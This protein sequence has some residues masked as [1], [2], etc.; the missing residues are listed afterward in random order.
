VD[1][2]LT[3]EN[4]RKLIIAHVLPADEETIALQDCLHR[5]PSCNLLSTIPVPHFCQSTMDGYAVNGKSL[6]GVKPPLELPI[7]GEIAAGC[8]TIA[9]LAE[10]EAVRIMTGGSVPAGAD[11]VIPFEWC[12]EAHGRVVIFRF[13]RKG[14]YIRQ[15]GTDLNK[16]QL[17]IRKGEM[18]TPLHLHLL[19]TSGMPLVRVFARPQVSFL[20]TGSEL[21][22]KSP[23]P[24]Q[25]ISGNRA[26]LDGLIR[27]AGGI[28][29]DLGVGVDDTDHIAMKLQETDTSHI[30]ITTG[31][32][33]PGKY[34]LMGEV[35]EKIGVKIL[36]RALQV[37][38]GRA[39]IFGVRDQTLFFSLPGPPPAVHM[40]FNEL[41]RP[42]I[43]A[44]QGKGSVP[45]K[46]RAILEEDIVIRKSGMLN[47]KS[48]ITA[49]R[50][51]LFSV[52][53]AG[54][55]EPSSATILIPANRRLIRAGEKVTIHLH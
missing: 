49:I 53:P 48:G 50:S 19:A 17:I 35:L 45:E 37:R 15:V 44:L 3:L 29:R 41:V 30:T 33:G 26:L 5:R 20:C 46:V 11:R 2:P 27:Q 18:I 7:V 9:A 52:R 6:A 54:L 4:A 25:I 55:T 10:G 21:V 23:L 39:T 28:P 36:Y 38:P 32:M 40:L 14:R 22:E 42:A 34:D 31:G 43:F 16:G 24:G 12:R 1:E 8:T 51:G 47:L 13:G